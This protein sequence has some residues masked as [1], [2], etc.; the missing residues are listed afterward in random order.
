MPKRKRSTY[1]RRHSG[2]PRPKRRRYTAR[3]RV[4]VP[5]SLNTSGRSGPFPPSAVVSLRYT[6]NLGTINPAAGLAGVYTFR[7]NSINDPNFTG[8]GTQPYGHDTLATVY[9]K[10]RV[11]SSKITVH[12]FQDGTTG[13]DLG[14]GAIAL[15]TSSVGTTDPLLATQRPSTTYKPFSILENSKGIVKLT[16]TF[17]TRKFFGNNIKSHTTALFALN[18]VEQ[19]FFHVYAQGITP[20]SDISAVYLYVT[21][22][23]R[24]LVSDPLALGAS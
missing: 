15:S 16:K 21:I 23:Y 7:A 24:V 22:T 6:D 4:G 12:M 9:S 19:A 11:L 18:P 13:A 17:N 14:I 10:Y 3:R 1:S 5:R 2:A 8:T 20:T